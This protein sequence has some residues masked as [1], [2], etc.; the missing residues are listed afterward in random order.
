MT[1]FRLAVDPLLGKYDRKATIPVRDFEYF[2]PTKLHRNPSSV[3]GEEVEN[4]NSITDYRRRTDGRR[5]MHDHK[6]SS[7]IVGFDC[8][9]VGKKCTLR[10]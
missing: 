5:T 4:I 1:N 7:A 9:I 6:R 10:L 2:I 3:S 8:Q